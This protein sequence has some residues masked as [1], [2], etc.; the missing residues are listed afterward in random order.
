MTIANDERLQ[1]CGYGIIQLE[2]WCNDEWFPMRLENVQYVP[3]MK[4]NL[5]S[6][7]STTAKGFSMTNYGD[8][9]EILDRDGE[10]K[11]FGISVRNANMEK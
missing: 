1:I 9:C 10:A 3:G 4:Q 7:A 8:H 11:A 5:F 6:T 2:A